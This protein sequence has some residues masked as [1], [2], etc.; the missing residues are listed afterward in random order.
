MSQDDSQALLILYKQYYIDTLKREI[1]DRY[2][3]FKHQTFRCIMIYNIQKVQYMLLLVSIYSTVL[4]PCFLCHIRS[5][6]VFCRRSS[7]NPRGGRWCSQPVNIAL[8]W[9][10]GALFSITI[11]QSKL[12]KLCIMDLDL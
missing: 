1:L 2:I 3:S 11:L 7:C 8:M 9:G 5:S 10:E 4:V 6:C 12:S